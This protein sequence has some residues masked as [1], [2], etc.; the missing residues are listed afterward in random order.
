MT[1]SRSWL[2][3]A[4]LTL[5]LPVN[6]A[7]PITYPPTGYELFQG[8]LAY[9]GVTPVRGTNPAIVIVFNP[10]AIDTTGL[11]RTCQRVLAAGG[12]VLLA[13]DRPTD[14]TPYFPAGTSSAATTAVAP[15]NANESRNWNGQPLCPLVDALQ[16]GVPD[17]LD[18]ALD[19]SHL[20]DWELFAGLKVATNAPAAVV[21]RQP[22]VYLSR[23]LADFQRQTTNGPG[24]LP[25]PRGSTFAVGGSGAGPAGFRILLLADPS[26]FS[27][28]MLTA[29]DRD[30]QPAD[31][32]RFA[33]N[34]VTWLTAGGTR[35]TCLFVADGYQVTNFDQVKYAAVPPLPPVDIDPLD[36]K[37][38]KSLTDLGNQAVAKLQDNDVPNK[39]VVGDSDEDGRRFGR[40]ARGVAAA[41]GVVGLSWLA[42]V[43]WRARH[44]LANHPPEPAAAPAVDYPGP[45]AVYLADLFAAAGRTPTAGRM[46]R[47]AGPAAGTLG[48]DIRIL[49]GVAAGTDARPV[50]ADRWREL[51]PLI[52]AVEDGHRAGRW[53]FREIQGRDE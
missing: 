53:R 45:V 40:A 49:W 7:D 13:A 1:L 38:Q 20:A 2:A 48:P 50:T 42:A 46:P 25:L 12:S 18:I 8:L 29:V 34:V 44:S 19:P 28:Q 17:Q 31:N 35:K 21:V 4:L 47:L 15:H 52:E 6:A 26:V 14:W 43:A 24:G 11:G 36:P 23:R 39:Q 37:L 22:G 10:P 27:N 32:G 3:V 16:P 30:D 9:H 51:R 33:N 5:G 41:A